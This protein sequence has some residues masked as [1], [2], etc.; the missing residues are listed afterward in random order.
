DF[1]GESCIDLLKSYDNLVLTRTFSKSRSLAGMR[2][3]FAMASEE[4]V[5]YMNAVKDSY[6]SY[7]VDA[8]AIAAGCASVDD[9][10]Y[11][12]DTVQKLVSTR[13]RLTASLEA[14]G[15]DVA[16]SSANF[17]FATHKKYAAKDIF[18]FLREKDIYVRYFSSPRIDNYLRITVGT[19]EE[20]DKLTAA[21]TEF[22]K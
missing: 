17:L 9:D 22:V 19:D 11:F 2:L 16:K 12:K 15:F 1:G 7:P 13:E 18:S 20:T 5:S 10:K 6:N 8:V 21:L 14:M 3:G 4:L